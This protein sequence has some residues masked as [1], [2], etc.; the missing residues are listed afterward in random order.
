MVTRATRSEM[1]SS[2]VK[3]KSLLW[4][5]VGHLLVTRYNQTFPSISTKNNLKQHH[6]HCSFLKGTI[7]N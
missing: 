3:I 2:K 5:F 6:F 4:L 1:P 7:E